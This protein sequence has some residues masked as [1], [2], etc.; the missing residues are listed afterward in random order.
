MIK[1]LKIHILIKPH[2]L[3]IS[4]IAILPLS[5]IFSQ[6]IPAEF[7]AFQLRKLFLE[8]GND[9]DDKTIFG[10]IRYDHKNIT[11]D[12]LMVNARFGT[13]VF[14]NKK[15]LYGYGHFTF[16]K[17]YHGYLYP[18]I[19]DSPKQFYRY[20]GISRDIE[21]WGFTSGETDISGISFQND[22]MIFQFG[23]GRQ[24]WG[25]GNDIQ[26]CLSENSNPYDYGLLDLDFGKLRV[27][28][29]HGYLETDSLAYNRYITGRGIEFNNGKYL[30]FGLS[31][32][33]IYSGKNRPIDFA[34]FNPMSTHLEIELNDRQNNIGTGTGNGVWQLSVDYK[35][36]EKIRLS[37]NYLFDEFT[38]DKQQTDDGKGSGRA[39]SIKSTYQIFYNKQSILSCFA[40]I[41]TVGTNTFKHQDGNNNFVQRSK[42]LGWN[43]G[44]DSKETKIGLNGVYNN[45]L[46]VEIEYGIQELGENNFV[47]NAYS[48][49]TDYSDGPFPSGMVENVYFGS[50]RLQWWVNSYF[51]VITNLRYNNSN[52]DGNNLELNIGIDIFYP[53]NTTL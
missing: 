42:P 6:E 15:M 24:S 52:L 51:S 47:N 1:K 27:R 5:K 18:R 9:W 21:R 43:I 28:Y 3:I 46:I 49:Y 16:K 33:I 13:R 48:G 25:A 31:E 12:S 32:V 44:S 20:S 14:N 29:F 30:I 4:I 39:F 45:K 7:R 2:L 36:L 37:G 50:S 34:Y 26:L 11:S 10:P 41:I 8:I 53:F 23:R 35:P 19:V 40:S 38:L 22:W 17:N